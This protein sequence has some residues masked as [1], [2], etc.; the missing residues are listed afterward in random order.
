L[1]NCVY[2]N[3]FHRVPDGAG[4]TYWNTQLTNNVISRGQFIEAV[5][6]GA[7]D[8]PTA[9]P[10]TFD[11]SLITNQTIAAQYY[12]NSPAAVVPTFT[13]A[14]ATAVMVPVTFNASSIAVS[15][16]LTND[17]AAGGG[18]GETFTLTTG[19]D[20][21]VGGAGN[22][23]FIGNSVPTSTVY[24]LVDS[25]TF[26]PLDNL[27]GG[28]GRN[29]FNITSTVGFN[30]V[31]PADLAPADLA[32]PVSVVNNPSATVKNIQTANIT[33]SYGIGTVVEAFDISMDR[34]NDIKYPES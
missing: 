9:T 34:F 8:A 30:I 4:A 1:V 21:F 2:Q 5:L 10:P 3:A 11:L 33:A 20:T 7:I 25:A 29:T 12:T 19:I 15:E 6:N 16:A 28:T 23:L 22:D 17:Y 14:G 26:T 18:I 24:G 27:D 32:F 13:V 31:A